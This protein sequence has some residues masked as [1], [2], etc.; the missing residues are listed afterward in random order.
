MGIGG[1]GE[2]IIEKS[3][4]AYLKLTENSAGVMH[5]ASSAA[6][7]DNAVAAPALWFYSKADPVSEWQDCETVINKWKAKGTRVQ[8][9]VWEDTP[10]IQHARVDPDRYFGTLDAFLKEHNITSK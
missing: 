7:H 9:C 4:R 10:H 6:F 3:A 5:K 1:L 8:E 2:K